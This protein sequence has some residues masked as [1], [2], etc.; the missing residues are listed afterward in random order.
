MLRES[1]V[2]YF[3]LSSLFYSKFEFAPR[4][5]EHYKIL[6]EE[7]SVEMSSSDSPKVSSDS[8]AEESIGSSAAPDAAAASASRKRPAENE[9]PKGDSDSSS[10]IKNAESDSKK[11]RPESLADIADTERKGEF[12]ALCLQSPDDGTVLKEQHQCKQCV[13]TAWRICGSCEEN[14]LSRTC[15]VCHGDYGC[16]VFSRSLQESDFHSPDYAC[17]AMAVLSKIK[18][19]IMATS[20][21]AIWIPSTRSFQFSLP[22]DVTLPKNEIR[23]CVA[24]IPESEHVKLIGDH[25][26]FTNKIWDALEQ[27]EDGSGTSEVF[28]VREMFAAVLASL[29]DPANVLLTP[30][31]LEEQLELVEATLSAID[32]DAR[33]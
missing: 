18:I 33:T 3:P 9:A 30:L 7:H 28:N 10:S 13:P 2:S 29:S 14:I 23:Y 25:F 1:T 15:P 19:Q 17:R 32:D 20:N 12:C 24:T 8:K 22:V 16:I 6:F 4:L 11:P 31:S 27:T 5:S 26:F 21:V